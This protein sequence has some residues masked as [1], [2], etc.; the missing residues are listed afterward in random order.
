MARFYEESKIVLLTDPKKKEGEE[1][2]E[3]DP[4]DIIRFAP[5]SIFDRTVNPEDSQAALRD[6]VAKGES[7]ARDSVPDEFSEGVT[8][9]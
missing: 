8:K 7:M 4:I 5:D 6:S 2:S 3:H 9:E 1:E